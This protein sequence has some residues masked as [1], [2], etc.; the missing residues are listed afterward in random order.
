[1]PAGSSG[2]EF[3]RLHGMGEVLYEMLLRRASRRRG[4]HLCAG[5]RPSRSAGL[6]G[7]A[8]VGERRQFVVRLGRRRSGGADRDGP[9]SGRRAGSAMRAHARH[10]KIPLPRDLYEPQR[11]NSAGVEFGDRAGLD[12]LAGRGRA[13]AGADAGRADRS[14]ASRSRRHQAT[15]LFAHRRRRRSARC[16]KATRRSPPPQWRPRERRLPNGTRRRSRARRCARTRRR[17]DGGAA[18]RG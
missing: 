12:A 6:S 18:R 1:M 5:R 15:G 2:Y 10:P 8:A 17:S 9:A 14:T 3:Q 11:R 4:A 7:A 13:A 16:G